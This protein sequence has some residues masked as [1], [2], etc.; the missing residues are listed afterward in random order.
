[1]TTAPLRPSVTPAKRARMQRSF[2]GGGGSVARSHTW[3]TGFPHGSAAQASRVPSNAQPYGLRCPWTSRS[4]TWKVTGST[5]PPFVRVAS[6][7]AASA[8]S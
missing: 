8:T 1:M 4:S 2:A 6:R 5:F 7:P 3:M